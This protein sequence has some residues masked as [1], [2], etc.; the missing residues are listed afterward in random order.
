[1]MGAAA[2][3]W[4]RIAIYGFKERETIYV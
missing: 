2:L 3:L 1:M 4:R